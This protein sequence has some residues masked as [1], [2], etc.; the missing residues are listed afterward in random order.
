LTTT[1]YVSN[2]RSVKYCFYGTIIPIPLKFRKGPD[3]RIKRTVIDNLTYWLGR[4]PH[5]FEII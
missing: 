2:M 5:L 1:L 3:Y 4:M